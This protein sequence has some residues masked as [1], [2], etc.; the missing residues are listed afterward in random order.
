MSVFQLPCST[1]QQT[2]LNSQK[3]NTD[4]AIT[5]PLPSDM[6]NTSGVQTGRQIHCKTT[7][8]HACFA[9][10][11]THTAVKTDKNYPNMHN[12]LPG[13]KARNCIVLNI[14]KHSFAAKEVE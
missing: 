10:N 4:M 9:T 14:V 1:T 8:M 2:R 12:I 13:P 5:E 7:K 6:A 3:F 11:G